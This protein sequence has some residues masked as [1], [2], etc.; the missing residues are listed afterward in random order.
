MPLEIEPRFLERPVRSSVTIPTELFRLSA[1]AENETNAEIDLYQHPKT[2]RCAL[3]MYLTDGNHVLARIFTKLMGKHL[4]DSYFEINK[5]ALRTV[6]LNRGY[7]S[8]VILPSRTIFMARQQNCEERLLAS[9]CPSVRR[10]QLGS[11][12]T[13]FHE[14]CILEVSFENLS[15]KYKFH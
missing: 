11:H 6:F 13:D 5:L 8:G 3:E 1:Q 4:G 15:N 7:V 2:V 10:E 12:W 14:S 9:S